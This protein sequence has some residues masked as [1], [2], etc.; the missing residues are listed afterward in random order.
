MTVTVITKTQHLSDLCTRLS[1]SPYVTV[2][3]EFLREKTYYS[4]LCLIQI[5]NNHE[6]A[7]IDPLSPELNLSPLWD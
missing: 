3:T 6:S 2:D 1:Q 4:K 7:I 5:A